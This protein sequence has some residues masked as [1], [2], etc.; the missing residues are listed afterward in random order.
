MLYLTFKAGGSTYALETNRV[1]CIVPCVHLQPRP[2]APGCIAGILNLRGEPVVVVDLNMLICR[3]P[4]KRRLST[5]IIA[6]EMERGGRP[7]LKLGLMA[8]SVAA[9]MKSGSPE[10]EE[11]ALQTPGAPYLGRM[12]REDGLLIQIID[13]DKIMPGELEGMLRPDLSQAK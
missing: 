2:D 9:L 13:I 1:I 11:N 12:F 7:P 5:R 8:A 3:E 6:V 4:C 10:F